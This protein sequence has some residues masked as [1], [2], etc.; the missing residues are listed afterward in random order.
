MVGDKM[1]KLYNY[2]LSNKQ[3]MYKLIEI[4]NNDFKDFGDKDLTFIR[5]KL[6]D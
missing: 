6:L 1:E 2:F 4:R 3:E 5:K